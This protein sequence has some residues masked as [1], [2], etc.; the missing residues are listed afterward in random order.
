MLLIKCPSAS[1]LHEILIPVRRW[2]LSKSISNGYYDT[3]ANWDE[4]QYLTN[5]F[6]TLSSW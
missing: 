4:S 2:S 6:Q 5:R 3:V 1:K